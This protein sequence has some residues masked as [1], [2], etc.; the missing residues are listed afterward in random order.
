MVSSTMEIK[1]IAPGT[2]MKCDVSKLSVRSLRVFH[3]CP[4][5]MLTPRLSSAYRQVHVEFCFPGHCSQGTLDVARR[6]HLPFVCA[7]SI[8]LPTGFTGFRHEG[9]EARL[10]ERRFQRALRLRTD[11]D[12][13]VHFE[14]T[15]KD[16]L[17]YVIAPG[18]SF[19][20]EGR[21]EDGGS[22]WLGSV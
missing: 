6:R 9:G 13:G 7:Q 12:P 3:S 8:S 14:Y 19:G 15:F 1:A 5:M 10:L 11:A 16:A 4:I 21:W 20:A 2:D 17:N 18:P 22:D